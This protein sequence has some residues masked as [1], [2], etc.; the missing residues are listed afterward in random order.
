MVG[1]EYKIMRYVIIGG[2]P[3]GATAALEIR[4]FD[5]KGEITLISNE[6]YQFYKRSKIINLVSASCSE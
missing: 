4:Q 3:A 2:G 5:V 1:G 6:N